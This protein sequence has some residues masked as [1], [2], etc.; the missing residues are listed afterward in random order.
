MA[1]SEREL[2]R[3]ACVSTHTCSQ[4][5]RRHVNRLASLVHIMK[6]RRS[7]VSGLGVLELDSSTL[8]LW[9]ASGG[10]AFAVPV[11]A[12][13]ARPTKRLAVHQYFFQIHATDRWWYLSGAIQ[14][15]YSR[16]ATRRLAERFEVPERAPRP[17]GMS[18]EAYTRLIKNPNTHQVVWA[19]SWLETLGRAGAQVDGR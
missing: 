16:P 11:E 10:S 15:R 18:V 5:G 6:G 3:R 17:T 1:D 8:S 19:A 9:D 4:S 2:G 7:L 12:V 14:T 13:Q